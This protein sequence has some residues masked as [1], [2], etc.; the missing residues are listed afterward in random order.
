MTILRYIFHLSDL[1]IRNGDKISC[2]YDE[3]NDV[4]NET[5]ISISNQIKKLNLLLNEYIIIISGDIFHNKNIIGNYGLLLYKNFIEH[6][7][8]LGRV[9][10]FHGNHDRNQSEIDQ[11][12]LVFS[13]TF[14]IDNL[15]ILN[16]STTF[17]IDNIGFSYVNI[18][19]TL[20]IYRNS[21]RIQ[22]LP[23]FPE[24]IGD[25]K[26]KIALFHGSFQNA[27]LFNG[28]CIRDENNPYPLEWVKDFDYVLLGDIHKRQVF[29]YKKKTICG[30]SG[31]LIQQ[32][33]G[34]NVV[35]HGYLIW[36][37][38]NKK[39][40]EINI[41]NKIG[42]INIKENETEEILIRI[43][44]KY[45]ILLKD[46]INNNK[47]YIPEK[48][49]IKTFSKINFQNLNTLL[50][51]FN[52]SFNIISRLDE[53]KFI[54]QKEEDYIATEIYNEAQMIN[55]VDNSFI[56]D[57]FSKYL[58]SDK[59]K[60]LHNI[61]LNKEQLLFDISKYPDDLH[62]ECVKRNKELSL[63]I[64]K[65]VKSDDIKHL[66]PKYFIKYVEWEGLFCYENKNCLNMSDLDLKTFLIKGKNGTGK[67]AIYDIL[68]LA[69][70]GEITTL[71]K[72][73]SLSSGIINYK[74]TLAYTIVDIEIDNI[75]YRIER[76]YAVKKDLTKI[77]YNHRNIYKFINEKDLEL[78]KKDSACDIL[79][80]QLF[81]T[82]EN[83]LSSSMITQNID[84]DILT[85]D[86][87]DC[88]DIIDKS[89]NIEY[90]NN[91]YNLFKTTINKYRDFRRIVESK[92]QVYEKLISTNKIK[93]VNDEEIINNKNKLDLLL[94]EKSELQ[95][96]FESN[97]YIKIDIKN[98]KTLLLL[99][100]DYIKLIED[101]K[102]NINDVNKQITTNEEYIL[103]KEQFNELKYLLKDETTNSLNIL[104]KSYNSSIIIDDNEKKIKPCELS[105]IKKED[106]LLKQYLN[107]DI[108]FK[109]TYIKTLEEYKDELNILNENY[110]DLNEKHKEIINIKQI[111]I[112]DPKI[113]NENH[114]K[115]INKIFETVDDLHK[116]IS[117]N[118]KE[119]KLNS[120]IKKEYTYNN[121]KKYLEKEIE[122]NKKLKLNKEKIIKLENDFKLTFSKQQIL[123]IKNK[124]DISISYKTSSIINKEIKKINIKE[125]LKTISDDEK[126]LNIYY[127]KQDNINKLETELLSYKQ[128]LLLFTS[129][130]DYKYNPLCEICCKRSWV[131]RIKELEIIINKLE[132]DI[133]TINDEIDNDENDYLLINERNDINNETK[134]RYELLNEWLEYY[135]SKEIYDKI[136]KEL[137]LIVSEKDNINKEI[138]ELDKEINEIKIIKINFNN[139]TYDLY[140]T[141]KNIDLY[142]KYKI[143]LDKYECIN[144]ELIIVKTNITN[145]EYYINYSTNIKPRISSL[146]ILK[147]QYKE[148]ED[149]ENKLKIIN[150]FKMFELNDMLELYDKINE[151]TYNNSLKPLIISKLKLNEEIKEIE[152]KIKAVENL[153][154]KSST[155][156]TY[157]KEN[158]ESYDK[159]F[160]ILTN[161]DDILNTLETII[162]NFQAFRIDMYDTHILN[163]LCERAN[164]IIKSLCH[165]DTKPFKLDYL[166]TVLKDSIHINWLINNE[167]INEIE[168]NNKQLISINQASGFQHFVI[169]LA[170]RMSLFVN[171]Q[172]TMCNQLF[173]DEGFI[174]FDKENLSIVP[175]FIKSLLS[176]FNNIVIVSHIDL[177]QDNIDEIAEIKY[178]KINSVSSMEYGNYKK[179][180]KKRNRSVK[181]T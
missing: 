18:D 145:L 74:K 93:E 87:K 62:S 52:I 133:K 162:I 58:S 101:L 169:S 8:K 24:I 114:L 120:I 99:D 156:N 127:E 108:K 68:T 92:K 164:K 151:Y 23:T 41:Y 102:K 166:I 1:H 115:E 128:E 83:F 6:L 176:Y 46:Y 124:P 71:K 70:W 148:W 106:E 88:I 81:G 57:Y 3:Y 65:C 19:D 38:E 90:I 73:T 152:V 97:D 100:I 5:I 72:N 119:P 28:D 150:A 146:K 22:D 26:Y 117:E 122:I 157:N 132:C 53:T 149:Y 91:L 112:I 86:F 44:G 61:I 30:Y 135:K 95:E 171:K 84:Y 175:S 60:I 167:K 177:I 21:G 181:D 159:L 27:K 17:N 155:I 66:K 48:L 49:E 85:M 160:E 131:C 94:K 20:D 130:D 33:F 165:N 40:N 35:E 139:I 105:L 39:I 37:L 138:I 111:E 77:N 34:E 32:S 75:L 142:E 170:L 69:I 67:S 47:K 36:D 25:V 76:D 174:N 78:I 121:Y 113:T 80:K 31:S 56:L 116:Y 137:N 12:S 104:N 125:L 10:I 4:F 16:D 54:G 144:K 51:S 89:C 129:K 2:R 98:P 147:Q 59:L 110:K 153:I 168:N 64:S 178:N 118:I 103:Y 9:I 154:V 96:L 55:I 50:K 163:K 79:I 134:K 15:T 45:E 11:P 82:V 158:R 136:T 123:K 140:E 109:D 43:N 42:Y 141:L 161:L 179:V 172:E 126:I 63:E 13:S 14:N 29:N 173:I 107:D 7:V 143:W 180:I